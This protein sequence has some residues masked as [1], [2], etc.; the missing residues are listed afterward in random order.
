M[1]PK[2]I[3]YCWL[4]GDPV[5]QNLQDYMATWKAKLPDYEFILWDRNRFDLHSSEWVRQAFEA[6]KYAFAADYIRLYAVYHYGGIYMDMDIEVVKP[7]DELLDSPYFFGYE[8]ED[9]IEAGIFGAEK[10][11]PLLKQCLDYYH[12][13][14]FIDAQGRMSITPLP[15]IMYSLLSADHRFQKRTTLKLADDPQT[16]YLFPNDYFTAKSYTT[17][18]VTRTRN[19]YTV[20]HFAGSWVSKSSK[21]KKNIYQFIRNNPLLFWVYNRSY[22]K[23]K[24]E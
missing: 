3:H 13:R 22:K 12:N 6:R 5:P 7:F 17:G 20:H 8:K 21:L 24:K 15:E 18:K 10:H 1:I 19:T 9:G 4:S 11:H 14:N 16:V 2:I 23:I